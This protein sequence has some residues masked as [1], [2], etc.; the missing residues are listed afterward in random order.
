MTVNGQEVTKVEVVQPNNWFDLLKHFAKEQGLQ[1]T[2]ICAAFAF[3]IYRQNEVADKLI[4]QAANNASVVSA[5]TEQSKDVETALGS[6][7]RMLQR[8]YDRIG[9]DT[10]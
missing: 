2:V 4:D 5:N 8:L 1:T 10:E 6:V 9:P 7:K 3:L